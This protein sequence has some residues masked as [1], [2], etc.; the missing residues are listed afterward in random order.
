MTQNYIGT[1]QVLA[2]EQEKDGQPGYGI[3]YPDGYVSWCPKHV[4]EESYLPMGNVEHLPAYQQ[5]VIGENVQLADKIEKLSNFVKS[6]GAKTL[7]DE[8]ADLLGKQL[9]FMVL[10]K[11]VLDIRES[12]F[13]A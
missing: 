5:R 12:K 1:K 3:K 9:A 13:N 11:T 10:Y 7:S 4:F 6:G 2:W 8:E